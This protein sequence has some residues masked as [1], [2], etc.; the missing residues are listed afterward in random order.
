MRRLYRRSKI[1]GFIDEPML[2]VYR[3]RGVILKDEAT[4]NNK[5]AEDRS[6]YQLVDDGW[7][8]VN[9]MKAWQGALGVSQLRG[10]ISGHYICFEP[11]HS[12]CHRYLHYALR[13]PNMTAHFASIS[14]GVRPGQIEIDNDDL[15]ATN[16]QLPDVD[17][18]RR[19]A[20]FLDDRV[21]RIDR[22]LAARRVQMAQAHQ[23]VDAAWG[24]R[25][26]LLEHSCGL[27]PLR[28]FLRSI[29]DGP[30]GSSLTSSHYTDAGTR[31]IRLGNIGIGAFRNDD[32]SFVSPEHGERLAAHAVVPGDLVMA[33]LG[34]ER[35]PLGRCAVVPS[36]VEPAIVKADCY[37]I[38]LDSRIRHDYAAAFLSS[39]PARGRAALL[40]RGATRARLNTDVARASG[41]AP[42]DESAQQNY[43]AAVQ[44]AHEHLRRGVSALVDSIELLAEYKTSLITAAVTGELDVTTAGSGVPA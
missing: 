17:E 9:R 1:L 25:T 19:I 16:V 37:R 31:V 4:N 38:R 36:E 6:I 11:V 32:T 12:D 41:L 30:F 26:R 7:L 44:S 21:A 24:E 23:A 35:W 18:Q 13:A 20:A 15:A 27:V 34:D 40:G 39:P 28:R 3:E 8:V 33:G 5:T 10:I 43:V 14:R 22:I 42:A 29:V 2:S